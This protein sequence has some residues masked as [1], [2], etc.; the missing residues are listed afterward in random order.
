[1]NTSATYR[2]QA[3]ARDFQHFENPSLWP[4]YPFLPL[5]RRVADGDDPQAGV[6]YDARGMTGKYGYTCTV[7]LRTL[8]TLPSTET[9]LLSGPRITYDSFDE[10]ADDGW[11]VD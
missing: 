1:M 3:T 2:R 11:I 10:L 6:L 4:P 8:F 9:E 5:I 7:F